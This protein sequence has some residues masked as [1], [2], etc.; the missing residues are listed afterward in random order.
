VSIINSSCGSGCAL[1]G[2]SITAPTG[3][4]CPAG[5]TLQYQVNGGGWSTTIPVYNQSSP[6]ENIQT[7]C[8]CNIDANNVSAESTPVTTLPGT[9]ANPVMPVNGTATVACLDLATQPTPPVVMACDGSTITPTGPT[10]TNN[11]GVLT[12]EGTRTYTWTYSCGTTSSSWSYIYTIERNPFTVPSNG[13]AT[14]ACVSAITVPVPPAVNSNCGEPIAPVFVSIVDVPTPLVCEGTRTYNYSYTDCEGNMLPWSF[15]YT[16]ERSPFTVPTNGSA[17]VNSPALATQPTPPVVMSNC[18]ETLTP[19]GPVVTNNPNPIVC[20][21][22]RTYTWTYTDCEGNT[23]SWSFI[24]TITEG[25]LPC[26]WSAE[27]NGA[28]CNAGNSATYNSNTQRFTVTST[29]CYYPNSFTSDALAFAQYDL[30][31]NGS[32]TAEVTSITGNALGWAGVTM[33][34]N[35]TAGAKKAQLMT[36]LS[37][38]K[39]AESSVLR[40]MEQLIR[41]NSRVRTDIG[42]ESHVPEISFLCTHHRMVPPG[43][44]SEHKILLWSVVS[45]WGWW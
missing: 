45:K 21:G 38:L 39:S 26:G 42:C 3:N 1:T 31:G 16:I 27:P 35:N 10:I 25:S 24:Y 11:P 14:V 5:S 2:G 37:D 6:V 44:I 17:T 22:M 20:T 9:L 43:I 33:R 19:T 12:C 28:G 23:L 30:C 34:E 7:R 40:P 13:T 32:I 8:A 36:N 29:N 41:S 15:V 18:G 4:P